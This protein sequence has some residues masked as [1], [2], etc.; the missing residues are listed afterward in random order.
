MTC[1]ADRNTLMPP[2]RAGR[3]LLTKAGQSGESA[4]MGYSRYVT[5][6]IDPLESDTRKQDAAE[7]PSLFGSEARVI[8][9]KDIESLAPSGG[10]FWRMLVGLLAIAYVI[11][12]LSGCIQSMRRERQRTEE[13]AA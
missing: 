4:R 2:L 12:A 13:I 9:A 1:N 7:L 6:Y 3:Y 11:E 10:E 5:T 8:A